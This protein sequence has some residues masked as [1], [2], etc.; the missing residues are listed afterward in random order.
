MNDSARRLSVRIP[1]EEWEADICTERAAHTTAQI[2]NI[3]AD[4]AYLVVQRQFQLDLIMT[5][6]IKSPRLSFHTEAKVIHAEPNG[7]GVRFLDLDRAI[8]A[9]ILTQ[10]TEHLTRGYSKRQ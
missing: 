10:I 1:T 3:S 4:G 9:S 7:I 8:R 6:C 5:M 2:I